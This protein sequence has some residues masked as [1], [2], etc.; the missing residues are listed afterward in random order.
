MRSINQWTKKWA[1]LRGLNFWY[2]PET[3]STNLIAKQKG[4]DFEVYLTDHQTQGR[5]R[6]GAQWQEG[7]VNGTLLS[8]WTFLLNSSPQPIASPL[9]GLAV[10]S[11]LKSVWPELQFSLKAPND[12]YLGDKKLAGLLIEGVSM[13]SQSLLVIGLGLNVFSAPTSVPTAT[14]L[15][16]KTTVNEESWVQFLDPLHSYFNEMAVL[17]TATEMPTSFCH[18]LKDAL[19]YFPLKEEPVTDVD[20]RGNIIS[21]DDVI[22]WFDL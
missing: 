13:G 20:P 9:F 21:G 22:R 18:Q 6:G 4:R 17:S 10:Y 15:E 16:S 2:E 3:T 8:S 14:Y 1:D 12:I 19:N 7:D 5:G 11:S